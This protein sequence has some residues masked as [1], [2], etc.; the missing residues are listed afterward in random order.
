MVHHV[1]VVGR[2]ALG[3]ER[4]RLTGE[5]SNLADARMLANRARCLIERFCASVHTTV[6]DAKGGKEGR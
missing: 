2:D 1:S 6:W 4:V 5:A 3:R